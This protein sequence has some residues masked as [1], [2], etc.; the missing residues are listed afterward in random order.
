[1]NDNRLIRREEAVSPVI[2]TI[3]MVAITVVLAATLYMM[4]GD[5]GGEGVASLTARI[6][7]DED[8]WFQIDSMSSPNRAHI[9]DVEITVRWNNEEA[10]G[11][12]E[13]E[14]WRGL[15]V[16]DE[17]RAGSRFNVTGLSGVPEDLTVDNILEIQFRIDGYSGFESVTP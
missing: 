13:K 3:L 4:V 2:A 16:D 8:T 7:H 15:N 12:L 6:S 9:D 10:T 11:Y 17:A 5:I 14:F 1:M